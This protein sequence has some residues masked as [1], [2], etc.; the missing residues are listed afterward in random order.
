MQLDV[1]QVD[2]SLPANHQQLDAIFSANMLHIS[3]WAS[4]AGLLQGAARHLAEHGRLVVYGPFIV[5][6]E[7]L[8]AGN[9]A[10]D[11]DLRQ[12]NEQWGLRSLDQVERQA[13]ACDLL[14]E[15]RVDMPANNL[16][17]V[18]RRAAL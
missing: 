14:L 6:G 12:R 3:P 15:Q 13:S 1:Q 9:Q 17:L 16:L 5:P 7:T 2:W 10:F 18:F 11:A 8:A 4:C